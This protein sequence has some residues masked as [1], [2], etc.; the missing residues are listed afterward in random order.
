VQ[1]L[2]AY[3]FVDPGIVDLQFAEG[4][5]EVIHIA[6]GHVVGGRALQHGDVSAVSRDRGDERRRGGTPGLFNALYI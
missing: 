6:G 4:L 5:G 2:A 1:D 3:D